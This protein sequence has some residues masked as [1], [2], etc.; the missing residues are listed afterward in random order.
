MTSLTYP[1]T[2]IGETGD[3]IGTLGTP[4]KSFRPIPVFERGEFAGPSTDLPQVLES[5]DAVGR[6]DALA[7]SLLAV[8]HSRYDGTSPA[9]SLRR[10]H[11][12]LDIYDRHTGIKLYEDVPLP[13]GSK[14]LG[15]GRFLY[16]LLNQDLP[17]WRIA[18]LRL[19]PA[20]G[21]SPQS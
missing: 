16:L 9:S 4:S 1:I 14:V 17:P 10:V 20:G 21:D 8:T 19:L 2:V 12:T 7:D 5:F 11:S 3:S 6:L 13:E 18:K 15:G